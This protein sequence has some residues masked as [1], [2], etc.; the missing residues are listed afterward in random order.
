MIRLEN[1]NKYYKTR[2]GRAHILRDVNLTV[3]KGERIGILGRNG[4]GKSTLI[5]LLGGV[6]DPSSGRVVRDMTVSWPLAFSGAF[7]HSLTGFDNLRFICRVYEVDPEEVLPKVEDF[8]EL[9]KYLFEPLSTYSAGMRARLG[10][11]I[12][13]VVDFDCYLIDE[14]VAVGDDRFRER[15]HEEL[16][17]KR[18]NRSIFLVSH[19]AD[20]VRQ[21]CHKAAVLKDGELLNF[22]DLEEAYDY[23]HRTA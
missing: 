14:I 9:G 8:A 23:Y 22:E 1:V 13:L 16:F 19:N 20:Y 12:S 4:A 21:H 2:R 7:Q 6:E 17:V 5:R 3:E 11:G 18:A 15:C 10:F